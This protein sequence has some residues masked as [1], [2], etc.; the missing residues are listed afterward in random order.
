MTPR[1]QDGDVFFYVGVMAT[2]GC[3]FFF[4]LHLLNTAMVTWIRNYHQS[5][6]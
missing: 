6:N 1:K 3:F 2:A 5:L 4:L